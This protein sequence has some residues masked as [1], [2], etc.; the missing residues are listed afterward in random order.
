MRIFHLALP[1][2][3]SDAERSGSYTL[4]TRGVTLEE[5]GFIHCSRHEQIDATRAAFYADVDDLLLL[6][7][8]TD[9][10][11]SPWQEDEVPGG[12]TFPHIYGAL[13]LDAV[14]NIESLRG[15]A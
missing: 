14:V 15:A 1:A 10:L 2:E 12:E 7:I 9:L 13:N 3:W 4:S 6:T 8:D 11:T 5:E